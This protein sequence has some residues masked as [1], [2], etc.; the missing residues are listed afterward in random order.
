MILVYV[1]NERIGE[2]A[3][4]VSEL[5]NSDRVSYR[6]PR[7]F[8][9]PEKCDQ[10]VVHGNFPAIREA[11]KGK[12]I[13]ESKKSTDYTIAELRDIKDSIDD[14]ESFT[15]GDNRKSVHKI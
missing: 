8:D 11:Y 12:L 4:L 15:E 3:D 10:V 13:S 2:V 1:T 14:W 5:K 7:Y 6:N 9:K